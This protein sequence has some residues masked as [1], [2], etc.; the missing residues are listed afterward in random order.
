MTMILIMKKR[1]GAFEE[2]GKKNERK[3]LKKEKEQLFRP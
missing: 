2:G 3:H 1:E